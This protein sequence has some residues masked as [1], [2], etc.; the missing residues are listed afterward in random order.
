[1]ANLTKAERHNRMLN[2]AFDTYH[3]QQ[4]EKRDFLPTIS[5]YSHFLDEAVKR[6]KIT[7]D[8]ARNQKADQVF[9]LTR[10]RIQLI[11]QATGKYPH[12]NWIN[13]A[14]GIEN[15]FEVSRKETART[16]IDM[17][18]NFN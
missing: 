13:E 2:N 18:F 9:K 17:K 10:Q 14:I 11:N 3:R 15:G 5:E 16:K 12:I 7:R 4:L 1:M 8:E 6:L